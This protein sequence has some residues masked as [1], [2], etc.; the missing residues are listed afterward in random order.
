MAASVAGA[1]PSRGNTT[2]GSMHASKEPLTLSKR[3]KPLGAWYKRDIS[4]HLLLIAYL[5]PSAPS[6]L[7]SLVP[8]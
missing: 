8:P 1:K 2:C 6:P 5:V 4:L 3:L 7:Q